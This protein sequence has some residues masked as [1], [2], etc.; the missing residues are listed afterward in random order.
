MSGDLKLRP[1][2]REDL[3]FVHR[4]NNDAKIM[5]YWFEEP[6]EA[7][8]ELQELYDKHIHD[9]SERRFILELDGQMVGLVELMEIDYIHRRAEFQI[10]IDPKFQGHG[11]AVSATKLA[12][13]YAFHVL[14][15]H[16]LYLV[17]DKVNEKA[18]HVYE[19]VGFI[20]EGELIDEFF[21]DGTYH[22]AIRMCIFQHQYQEMDI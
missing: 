18:I 14:N 5:S 16:K 19:K 6:Y 7:F 20:R 21:V 15:L 2:E 11:Y 13:K 22:D 9:Q 10:I 3:K 12:M 4:L 17:V 1:L 8:V